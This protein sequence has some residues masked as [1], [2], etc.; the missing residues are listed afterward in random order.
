MPHMHRFTKLCGV[1]GHPNENSAYEFSR[2]TLRLVQFL[3]PVCVLC[4]I[5]TPNSTET[6]ENHTFSESRHSDKTKMGKYIFLLQTT[7][8][9]S[10]TKQNGFYD[11]SENRHKA[12][13]L[14]HYVPHIS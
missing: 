1:Q 8:L 9:Q 10:Y 6:L 3:H 11:I 14:P 4:A 12:C 7:K 5:R 13:I 2:M